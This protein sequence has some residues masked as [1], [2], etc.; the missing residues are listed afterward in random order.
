[1]VVL[2]TEYLDEADALADNIVLINAGK[3]VAEGTA[4]ELKESW[5]RCN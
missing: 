3:V 4:N 5:W 2:T 1:M